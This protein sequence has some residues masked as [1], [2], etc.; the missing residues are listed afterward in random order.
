MSA[1]LPC[2]FCG[3]NNIYHRFTTFGNAVAC[4]NCRTIGPTEINEELA[5]QVW[6]RRTL[7]R[8]E[9]APTSEDTSQ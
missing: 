8:A 3:S 5:L 9:P 2:P 1:N 6:N 4:H 7:G